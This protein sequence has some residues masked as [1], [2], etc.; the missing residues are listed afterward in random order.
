MNKIG[1]LGCSASVSAYMFNLIYGQPSDLSLSSKKYYGDSWM[2]DYAGERGGRAQDYTVQSV[3]FP[4][5]QVQIWQGSN[6][7]LDQPTSST[8]QSSQLRLRGA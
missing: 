6:L 5:I 8:H 2:Q 4:P 1:S 7:G 3:N